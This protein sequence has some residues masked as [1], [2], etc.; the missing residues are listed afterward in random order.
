ME[1]VNRYV[2]AVTQHLPINSREDVSNELRANI[3]DMLPENPSESDVRAVLEELGNPMNLADE[4]SET[5]RYLI[6]PSLYDSYF[7]VLKLVVGIVIVVF[8]SIA[9]ISKLFAP[10]PDGGLFEMSI[11]IFVSMIVA[12]IQ[13]ITQAFLWV[14]LIFIILEKT[15]KSPSNLP[16][17]RKNWSIDDLPSLPIPDKRKISRTETVFSMFCTIFFTALLYFQ[18][19]FIGIYTKVGEKISLMEPLFV[20]QRLQSYIYIIIVLAII[21]LAIFI[22]KFMSMYWTRPLAI[23]NFVYNIAACVLVYIMIRD[24]SLFNKRFIYY[25]AN[26]LDIS[27]SMLTSMWLRGLSIFAVAFIAISIW[28]SINGFIKS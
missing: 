12:I 6:D 27:T 1:L 22:Y 4:Y 13:G 26:L 15:G 3:E 16:F 24:H 23:A 7:S 17:S 28:D 21:Q 11:D 5:K 18:P 25:F 14:T 9:L 2:Y 8:A 20:I 10:S 19:Q